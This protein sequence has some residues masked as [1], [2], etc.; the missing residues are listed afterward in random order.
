VIVDRETRGGATRLNTWLSHVLRAGVAVSAV[1]I[2]TG[3]AIYLARHGSARLGDRVFHGEPADLRSVTGIVGGVRR[4]ESRAI[5]QLGLLLLIATPIARVVAS[6]IGFLWARDRLYVAL[7][8][9]V[10]MLLAYSLFRL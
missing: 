7:T 9:A 10:L 2:L 6:A 5:V 8:G 3:A 1:V 4:L